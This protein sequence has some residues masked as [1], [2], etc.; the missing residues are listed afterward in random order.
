MS[1]TDPIADM[2]AVIKNAARSGK[3]TANIK[4]SKMNESIVKIFRDRKLVTT[5]KKIEDSRQGVIRVYLRY[6][7]EKTPALTEVKRISKPGLRR[8]VDKKKVPRVLGGMG[9]AIISTSQGLLT[10]EEA[11]N[12]GIGGEILLQAW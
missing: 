2:L 11:R 12:R 7:D 5:Y 4:S 8:Y 1:I 9:F 6:L 10:D 3:R